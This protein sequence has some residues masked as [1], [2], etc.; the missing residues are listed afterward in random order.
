MEMEGKESTESGS[1]GGNSE[2]DSPP[3]SGGASGAAVVPEI[4][5]TATED[6]IAEITSSPGVALSVGVIEGSRIKDAVIISSDGALGGTGELMM[7]KKKRGRPRKYDSEGNLRPGYVRSAAQTPSSE[8]TLGSKRG[9]GR[10]SGSGIWK[11]LG[12]LGEF[13]IC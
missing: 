3:S 2:Y 8:Y 7:G 1:P 10:P 4:I 12:S 9:R 13:L 6:K 11:T 5:N